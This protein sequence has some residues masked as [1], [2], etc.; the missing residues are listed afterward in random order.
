MAVSESRTLQI[1][2]LSNAEMSFVGLS[3]FVGAHSGRGGVF[4]WVSATPSHL[5]GI[6][7][8][9]AGVQKATAHN[10]NSPLVSLL[11]WPKDPSAPISLYLANYSRN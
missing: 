3:G 8:V 11:S 2:L 6:E 5:L 4:F 10:S 7:L 1:A 9:G